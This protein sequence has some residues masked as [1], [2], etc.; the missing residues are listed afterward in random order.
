MPG[1]EQQD[2]VG[3]HLRVGEL[4]ARLLGLDELGDEVIAGIAAAHLEQ[5]L[6]IHL[7][8]RVDHIGLRDLLRRQRDWIENTAA[9]ARAVVEDLAMLLGDAEHVADD[10]D[11]QAKR[12]I[13]DQVHVA[14]FED[15]IDGL[16][17]D[18]LDARPH[19]LDPA[20][21]E[22]FH[23]QA[24]QAGVVRRI[25]LQHPMAHAAEHRL[26]HGLRAITADGAVDKILAEPL[27]AYDEADFSVAA[28]HERAMRVDMHGIGV[29]Q[30]LVMW[31]G[32]ADEIRRQR[33]EQRLVSFDPGWSCDLGLHMLVHVDLAGVQLDTLL[34]RVAFCPKLRR[35][36]E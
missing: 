12:E 32:I 10:G 17:D 31:I 4:V 25:L 20:R 24:A 30:S 22:G 28:R 18:F 29:P 23:D 26:I 36:Q 21:G 1:A 11:R 27:V 7:R 34:Y 5:R 15:G 6:E 8:H 3:S 35:C 33:I 16:V 9:I 19:V 2:D 14:L 13:L